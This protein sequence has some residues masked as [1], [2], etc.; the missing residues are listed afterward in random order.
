[1]E[2]QDT[3]A[4]PGR[5]EWRSLGGPTQPQADTLSLCYSDL[6]VFF[7]PAARAT[8]YPGITALLAELPPILLQ[9][10]ASNPC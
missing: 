3:M 8:C 7:D 9:P 6:T 5:E 2:P 1:M 4:G 10:G